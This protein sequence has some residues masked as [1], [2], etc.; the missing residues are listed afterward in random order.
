MKMPRATGMD[1][2]GSGRLYIASLH[3]GSAVGYEGPN[4]G[5]V[6]RV[7]PKGFKAELFPDL[8]KAK[9]GELIEYLSAPQSVTRLHAQGEILARGRSTDATR[10]LTALAFDTNA[11]LEGRVAAIFTLKQLDGKD[12][13]AAMLKLA[14]TSAVREFAL[15]ALTDRKHEAEGLDRKS[16]HCRPGR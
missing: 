7:V 1:I 16:L 11:L 14:E 3:G 15:R 12:S 2:D 4:V 6:A 9:A 10:A 5:F 13:H 8:K